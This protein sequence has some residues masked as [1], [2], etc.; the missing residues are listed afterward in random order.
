MVAVVTFA[1]KLEVP[2]TD[3]TPTDDSTFAPLFKTKL[4]SIDTVGFG[5]VPIPRTV[6]EK[7]TLPDDEVKVMVPGPISAPPE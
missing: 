4:P 3:K 7:I 6:S 2:V 5:L 1:A